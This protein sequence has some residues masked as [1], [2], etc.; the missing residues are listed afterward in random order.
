MSILMKEIN[1]FPGHDLTFEGLPQRFP[2]KESAQ[3]FGAKWSKGSTDSFS[4][5]HNDRNFYDE[6]HPKFNSKDIKGGILYLTPALF[7]GMK[8]ASNEE[9]DE[10]SDI[11]FWKYSKVKLKW[12]KEYRNYLKG[13][14]QLQVNWMPF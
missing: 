7:F 5:Y 4:V 9:G 6:H 10:N 12:I 2:S 1:D 8:T 3:A 11:W 14:T 13:Y